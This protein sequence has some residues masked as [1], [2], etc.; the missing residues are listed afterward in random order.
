MNAPRLQRGLGAFSF[1]ASISRRT[2]LEQQKVFVGSTALSPPRISRSS[3]SAAVW[4]SVRLLVLIGDVF[5]NFHSS[6]PI[7]LA[8]M[9][10]SS[11]SLVLG[12]HPIFLSLHKA[13]R[14]GPPPGAQDFSPRFRCR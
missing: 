4:L 7:S 14:K 8:V 5:N 11:R 6:V 2:C 1:L 12:F 3:L 13:S 9:V 10:T